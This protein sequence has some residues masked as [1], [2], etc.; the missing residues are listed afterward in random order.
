MG[1]ISGEFDQQI[2]H[3]CMMK[4]LELYNVGKANKK[5]K[6][7]ANRAKEIRNTTLIH[8]RWNH[9]LIITVPKIK[10]FFSMTPTKMLKAIEMAEV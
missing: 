4:L 6:A 9:Q 8:A 2:S 1:K 3:D 10:A 5:R 7:S